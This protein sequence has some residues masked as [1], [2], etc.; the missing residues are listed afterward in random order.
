VLDGGAN[1]IGTDIVSYAHAADYVT[2]DLRSTVQQDTHGAGL[3]TLSNFET[4][5]GSDHND[6]LIG[7][8]SNILEGAA[9]NDHLIGQPSEDVT[10]SYE[11]ATAGV[12]VDLGITV[13]QFTR[14]AGS[15]TL[16]DIANLAGSHFNDVLIGNA[17]NNFFLGNGGNDTFVFKTEDGVGHDTIGDFASGQDKID[18]D[19]IAFDPSGSNDFNAWYGT[20]VTQQNNGDLLIDLDLN[21]HNT[22]LLKNAS[23]GGLSANDF[24]LH[25]GGGNTA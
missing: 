21:G 24:I 18:L 14:G 5:L 4:V 8:G 17:N 22:I 16:T 11:H 1:G 25:P 15:D 19:Y 3:D 10:A 7:G 23:F 6:T 2:V 12:T 9:G 20:H 13:Q